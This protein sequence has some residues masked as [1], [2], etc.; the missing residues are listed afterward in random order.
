M[1]R[2]LIW[3]VLACVS[4]IL[5]LSGVAAQTPGVSGSKSE[6]EFF[7][8]SSINVAKYELLLKR[9]TEVT[10]LMKVNELTTVF[11]EQN[12]EVKLADLRAGDTLWIISTAAGPDRLAVRIRKGPMTVADLR[13]LYTHPPTP[14]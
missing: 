1:N 6:E 11:D 8:L 3:G 4:A 5:I 9:P 10:T 12:R 2:L 13:R 7:I 14:R